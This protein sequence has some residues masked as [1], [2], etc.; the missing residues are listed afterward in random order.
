M[1]LRHPDADGAPAVLPSRFINVHV[2]RWIE[3]PVKQVVEK[4]LA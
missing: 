3:T 2:E 1:G 4:V